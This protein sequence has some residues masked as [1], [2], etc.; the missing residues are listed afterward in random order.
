MSQVLE[1]H[2]VSF[3][4]VAR[5]WISKKTWCTNYAIMFYGAYGI[6]QILYVFWKDVKVSRSTDESANL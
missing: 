4:S 3:E 2:I 6:F 1:V 5:W